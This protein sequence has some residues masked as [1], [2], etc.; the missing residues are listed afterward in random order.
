MLA[1]RPANVSV[2][3]ETFGVEDE[4]MGPVKSECVEA[5]SRYPFAVAEEG[6]AGNADQPTVTVLARI[7]VN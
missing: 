5:S 3:S 2:L 6:E 7:E 4:I 1:E